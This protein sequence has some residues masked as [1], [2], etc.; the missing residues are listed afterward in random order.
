MSDGKDNHENVG[1][2]DCKE[3]EI[4]TNVEMRQETR[5]ETRV[6]TIVRTKTLPL[7]SSFIRKKISLLKKLLAIRSLKV[8]EYAI[9]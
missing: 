5:Q 2:R 3:K 8:I 6:R 1:T 7:K 9:T 4:K